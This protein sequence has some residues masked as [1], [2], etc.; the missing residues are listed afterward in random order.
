MI[1]N[2]FR[3]TQRVS[4]YRGLSRDKGEMNAASWFLKPGNKN[5]EF[6]L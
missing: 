2:C 6:K 5:I 1:Y 4:K 3:L